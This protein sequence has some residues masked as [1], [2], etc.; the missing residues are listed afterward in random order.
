MME[1]DGKMSDSRNSDNPRTLRT[2]LLHLGTLN[3]FAVVQPVFDR[4]ISNPQ[5]LR[6]EGY[7]GIAITS[8]VSIFLLAI[9]IFATASVGILRMLR[10]PTVA[11][12][13]FA[14]IGTLLV[15]LLINIAFR[16]IQWW[17]DLRSAGVPDLLLAAMS[18]PLGI[19]CAWMY[20]RFKWPGQILNLA[21]IGIILFPLNLLSTP[22]MR[23]ELLGIQVKKLTDLR[24]GNPVPIV[25]IAF[26]GLCSMALLNERHEI[27]A[28]RYPSFARL[29]NQSTFYRNATAVHSRTSHALPAILTGQLPRPHAVS[30]VESEYPENLFRLI[31][32]TA[33]YDMTV[34]EPVTF[35]C[36]TELRQLD[37]T[38]SFTGQVTRLTDM[39]LRV[40]VATTAPAEVDFCQQLIP[41]VWF[42]FMSDDSG[43]H[44]PAKGLVTYNWDARHDTQVA[45]FTRTL[46]PT[47][48]PGFH[49]LHVVI[50]H[51]PWSYMPSGKSYMMHGG[52]A[53]PTPGTQPSGSAQW[54]ADE[55]FVN[56]GWQ[57]YLLQLQFA[58][59]CLGKILEQ[60]EVTGE[61]NG[62]LVVVVAD[63]GMAFVAGQDR[64][65][66]ANETLADLMSVPIFIKTPQQSAGHTTDR[67]VE[68]IDV[69]PTIADIIRMPLPGV[70]DGASLVDESV[71]ERPR[72]TMH[73]D[74][75]QVTM[76]NPEFPQRFKYVDR[77]LAVFGS[78]SNADR[79]WKLN[80][81]PELVG[82]ELAASDIGSASRWTCNL[83]RG[84]DQIDPEHPNFVPCY[85]SGNLAGPQLTH[86]VQIAIALNGR[87]ECTTRTGVDTAKPR[88]WTALLQDVL[89]RTDG[90]RVQLYEV[91]QTADGCVLHEIP[92]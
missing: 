70:V 32:D 79:M 57:R 88:E 50:P 19:G 82:I 38:T 3:A 22:A 40:Y 51:D 61:F 47:A 36:P 23:A 80:T 35:L 14:S 44:R 18:L 9:P 67:S 91:E 49:F 65:T 92:Y 64:R 85:F 52:I 46:Q 29:A 21:A 31:H 54:V 62:S 2:C 4:M 8:V 84:G 24:A 58:D 25:M 12:A 1:I 16:W 33:Q 86:P 59:R 63:H 30:A 77:M 39:L 55:L 56:L 76:V 27:D 13:V 20:R 72:K 90:N 60:L 71:S 78:G 37:Q 81:I 73:F 10:L 26:D 34:F 74:Y 45:H 66:P 43:Q 28:V 68:T 53:E 6:L 48:K 42:G 75:D 15:A 41:K 7:S 11:T 17:F 5:Y 69:L 83:S 87:I 89:F